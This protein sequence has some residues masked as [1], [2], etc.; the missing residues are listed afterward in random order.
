MSALL[1]Y[2]PVSFIP[3][4]SSHFIELFLTILLLLAMDF[5]TVKNISGRLLVGLRWWNKVEEDGTSRWIFESKK[6]PCLKKKVPLQCVIQ[7]FT[8]AGGN[9]LG[10]VNLFV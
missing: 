2:C 3:G 1:V 10:I 8:L 7:D 5:W 9:V 4:V 6:V